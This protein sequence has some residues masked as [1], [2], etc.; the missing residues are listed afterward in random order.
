MHLAV[1]Y[2]L[3][4]TAGKMEKGGPTEKIEIINTPLYQRHSESNPL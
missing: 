3:M 4:K 1:D 2:R